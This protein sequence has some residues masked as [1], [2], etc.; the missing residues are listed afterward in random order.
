MKSEFAT[1]V[2]AHRAEQ[3]LHAVLRQAIA[4]GDPGTAQKAADMIAALSKINAPIDVRT[5][6]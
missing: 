5:A 6:D 4:R 2:A 3:Q 1:A